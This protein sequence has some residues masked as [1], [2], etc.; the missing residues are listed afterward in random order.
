VSRPDTT[1]RDARGRDTSARPAPA[2][3]REELGEINDAMEHS[4][5]HEVFHREDSE[6]SVDL[7]EAGERA[8]ELLPGRRW[9]CPRCR[10]VYED[11][12][13]RCPE[14][15][16]PLV[17]DLTDV[18]LASRYLLRRLIGVGGMGGT[19][20]RGWQLSTRRP[21]AIKLLPATNERAAARFAR[22]AQIVSSLNHPHITTVH[23]YGKS[24]DGKLF[25]V[26]ELLRGTTVRRA[27]KQHGPFPVARALAVADQVLG[28]LD[29]AHR[30]GVVHRDLKTGN[31]FLSANVDEVDY[32][33]VL[34]FGIAEFIAG[35]GARGQADPAM[36][37]HEGAPLP[38]LELRGTPYYMAPEQLT[39]P[40][41]DARTDLYALGVVLYGLLA[42]RV[43]FRA[44]THAE[45]FR[46]ILGRQ[47]PTF[48]EAAPELDIPGPV[49]SFV[50]QVRRR[51][52]GL[53]CSIL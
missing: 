46:E 48:A 2:G 29:H 7:K 10:T 40:R 33:K 30:R 45:L 22:E 11:A 47:P 24:E 13:E 25:L 4:A 31:L 17:E 14:D 26:M 53:F 49:E 8:R 37:A 51:M 41:V 52:L 34:D 44:P 27:L 32:I 42:G 19:V 9:T 20:W 50:R 35:Q 38:E 43:P 15:S 18:V 36:E 6:P 21:V 12:R 3:T 1:R 28:A 23:D 39:S 5:E 16:F